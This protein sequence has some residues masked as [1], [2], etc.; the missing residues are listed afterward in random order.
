[1][2]MV[3]S[4]NICTWFSHD[5][6]KLTIPQIAFFSHSKLPARQD[7]QRTVSWAL[8]PPR[9]LGAGPFPQSA[10][11]TALLPLALNR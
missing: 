4:K 8:S 9:G 2:I 3:I 7:R 1:M 6:C 10:V 11:Q 5:H